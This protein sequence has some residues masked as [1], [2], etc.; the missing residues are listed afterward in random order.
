VIS[1]NISDTP[2]WYAIRTK[3]IQEFRAEANLL[4]W[5]IVT[6]APRMKAKQFNQFTGRPTFC[7]KPLFSR[8]VFGRFDASRLL[9]KVC[10]TRG[11]DTVVCFNG[12]PT[13]IDDAAIAL[14]QSRVGAD[15]IVK[16]DDELQPGDRV[17]I[18]SGTFKGISG[19]FNRHLKDSERVTILLDSIQFQ[20]KV[21][22][23]RQLVCREGVSL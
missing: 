22:V 19:V 12:E 6:F 18:K 20:A 7:I 13:P 4:A 8:Y 1:D 17:I 16:L 5:G 9:H 3:P 15:G 14:I 21:T 23:D 2:R 11:V 10:Y